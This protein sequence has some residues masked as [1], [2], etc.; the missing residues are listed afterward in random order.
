VKPN[1][2]AADRYVEVAFGETAGKLVGAGREQEVAGVGTD[3]RTIGVALI[4]HGQRLISSVLVHAEPNMRN[5]VGLA[6]APGGE[7]ASHQFGVGAIALDRGDIVVNDGESYRPLEIALEG[8]VDV[9]RVE[10]QR[11]VHR[12]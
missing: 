7:I 1:G 9:A 3:F 6:I 10:H 5:G 4:V 2:A 12:A 8:E 11:A